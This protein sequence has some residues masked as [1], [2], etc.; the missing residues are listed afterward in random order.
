MLLHLVIIICCEVC[1]HFTAQCGSGAWD[2]ATWGR[3][4][5]RAVWPE[6]YCEIQ[7]WDAFMEQHFNS[8][9]NLSFSFFGVFILACGAADYTRWAREDGWRR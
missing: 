3:R 9:T 2:D 7:D 4:K 8:L 5:R 6:E 1:D